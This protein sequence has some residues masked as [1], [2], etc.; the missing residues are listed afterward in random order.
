[1]LKRNIAKGIKV[2]FTTVIVVGFLGINP[3]P[4]VG[5]AVSAQE[6]EIGIIEPVADAEIARVQMQYS[7]PPLLSEAERLMVPE[8]TEPVLVPK[9]FDDDTKF[10]L[11]HIAMAEM[12]GESTED[13]ARAM[14]VVLNRCAV[15]G[16]TA[17]QVVF[18][19]NQFCIG[20]RFNLTPN[21]DCYVALALVESGWDDSHGARWFEA[22]WSA[23]R[24]TS[25]M[26][27]NISR[28]KTFVSG[29]STF[30]ALT[31]EWR[32]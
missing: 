30:Y 2:L 24:G 9:S 15:S 19:P 12:E 4:P 25:W 31:E 17:R 11:L 7:N 10:I 23:A 26:Q 1:M 27:R 32:D 18:A 22:N 6:G 5:M 14:L 29:G 8:E 13:K 16:Q 3:N 21:E 28:M 20:D